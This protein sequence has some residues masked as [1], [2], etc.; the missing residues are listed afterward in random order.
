[1]N[2]RI[3]KDYDLSKFTKAMFLYLANEE[4]FDYDK[5]VRLDLK[6]EELFW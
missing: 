6:K 1:M 5:G 2:V 4:I 3:Y